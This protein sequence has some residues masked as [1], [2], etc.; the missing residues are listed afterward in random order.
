MLEEEHA[1][2]VAN[3]RL[4]ESLGVSRGTRVH[5]LEAGRVDESRLGV[6]GMEGTATHVAP[7][8]TAHHHRRRE[9]GAISRRRHVVGQH[10]VGIGDE[11]DELHLDH[12][13][14]PHVR[15]A[16]RGAD[17]ADLGDRAV[18]DARF[19][20]FRQ[21]ALSDLE[22]ATV[23]TDVLTNHEDVRIAL[24]LLEQSLANG[25]EVGDLRH[26]TSPLVS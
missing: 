22:R 24:H 6:L 5:D 18:D 23:R 26:Q 3:G 25:L 12:G 17:D 19:P 2:V 1:I 13:P 11:V 15:G 9:E 20:E 4:H 7:T 21:Q 8:G 16:G 14:Q 10:V